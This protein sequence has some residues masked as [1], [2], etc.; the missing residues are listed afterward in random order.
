MPM[1]DA[2]FYDKMFAVGHKGDC[3]WGWDQYWWECDC[4]LIPVD[5]LKKER[6]R[7]CAAPWRC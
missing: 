5:E 3:N 4:G 6:D 1:S 2:E 7:R